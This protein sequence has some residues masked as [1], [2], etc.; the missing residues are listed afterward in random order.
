MAEY[1]NVSFA[2]FEEDDSG[3]SSGNYGFE[4]PIE[5]NA[6]D[7]RLW[8]GYDFNRESARLYID[9]DGGSGT[10]RLAFYPNYSYALLDPVTDMAASK[11]DGSQL[12]YFSDGMPTESTDTLGG[13]YDEGAYYTPI[14]LSN[15]SLVACAG[16]TVTESAQVFNGNK[17]FNDNINIGGSA[18]LSSTLTVTGNTTLDSL[19]DVTGATT[20]LDT[21]DVGGITTLANKLVF[22]GTTA[23]TSQIYFSRTDSPSYFSTASGGYFCFVP[24]GKDIKAANSD[25]IIANGAVYPGTTNATSLGTSSNKWSNVYATT[26]TGALSGN[27]SSANKL[28]MSEAVGSESLPI[29]FSSDGVPVACTA[30]SLFSDFSRS[31]RSTTT[32]TLSATICGQTLT[33]SIAAATT[34]YAG[35]LTA[36]DQT[37]AG[38]KTFNGDVTIKGQTSLQS[39]IVI[40]ADSYGTTLPSSGVEGQVFFLLIE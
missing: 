22:S 10:K 18:T 21:L 30:A 3:A 6:L 4:F 32:N 9:L 16:T 38:A 8:V 40:D 27:A 23:A 13:P 31:A 12:V 33:L 7:G 35:L 37:I 34:S 20:L 1:K 26:F 19:L 25:L 17:T 24:N 15:G 39:T 29:Y 36:A 5:D 28:I 14:Y 2:T 11:G